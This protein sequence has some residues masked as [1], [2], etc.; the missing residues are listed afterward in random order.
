MTATVL[1]IVP[2]P[3]GNLDDLSPRALAALKDSRV[4]FCE[5]TRRTGRLC[6]HFGI[7]ARL[8]R[9]NEHDEKSVSRALERLR[10]GDNCSV[11]SDGGTPCVSDP[12]WKLVALARA[13]GVT[14]ESI[15][16]PCAAITAFAA[17]GMPV[18]G[19][20]FLG[21]LPRKPTKIEQAIAAAF[22]LGKP[23]I[24][25]ESPYR[26]VKFLRFAAEKFGGGVEVFVARE[27][28]K[29]HEECFRGTLESA[30]AHFGKR[31]KIL[32]EVSV[33]LLP[34]QNGGDD[35]HR[36][37]EVSGESHDSEDY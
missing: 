9:Y 22:T 11:V 37:E 21:F 3:L 15:P 17:S 13:E 8:E 30:L 27:L 24:I 16:G 28:T 1:R 29:L 18:G 33:I 12:G 23:V 35:A 7:T 32:G 34:P 31:E 5:D 2:T 26:L 6:S 4:I 20:V 10:L 25:Y 19:F 36:D 14:V